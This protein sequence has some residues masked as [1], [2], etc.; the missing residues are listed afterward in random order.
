MTAE[1]HD[2]LAPPVCETLHSLANRCQS[3]LGATSDTGI[4]EVLGHVISAARR[5][6]S[7]ALSDFLCRRA[8]AD[9]FLRFPLGLTGDNIRNWQD[10]VRRAFA[11]RAPLDEAIEHLIGQMFSG[12]PSA[13]PMAQRILECIEEGHTNPRIRETD[14]AKQLHLSR[15]TVS[16]LLRA[17]G[18]TFRTQLRMSRLKH[19]TALMRSNLSFKEVASVCGYPQP[20]QLCRDF[21]RENHCSPSAYRERFRGV[22]VQAPLYF[23]DGS[24]PSGE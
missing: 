23:G 20:S 10:L 15:N 8:L 24:V 6:P 9:I 22:T 4:L 19:A 11:E 14:V 21:R 17:A 5:P 13:P 16:R 3:L 2:Q 7:T 18:T 12:V 1:E